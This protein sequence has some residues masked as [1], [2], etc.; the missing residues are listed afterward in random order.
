[1]IEYFTYL[2][3]TQYKLP[4]CQYSNR[5]QSAVDRKRPIDPADWITLSWGSAEV[6]CRHQM[7][8]I[9]VFSDLQRN[10]AEILLDFLPTITLY[11][12]NQHCEKFKPRMPQLL[13]ILAC[14]SITY[15]RTY[16]TGAVWNCYWEILAR[17]NSTFCRRALIFHLSANCRAVHSLHA[18]RKVHFRARDMHNL[19]KFPVIWPDNSRA[20]SA[21]S[22]RAGNT[23]MSNLQALPH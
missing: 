3:K 11:L 8:K 5:L 15:R 7:L 19:I 23:I 14:K 20:P 13:I 12:H 22:L 9:T 21:H 18:Q 1:M 17:G 10:V 4:S 16:L 2:N 6:S